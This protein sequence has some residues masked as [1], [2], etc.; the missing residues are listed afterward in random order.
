MSKALPTADADIHPCNSLIVRTTSSVKPVLPSCLSHQDF[1]ATS[2]IFALFSGDD[3]AAFVLAFI[4]SFSSSVCFLPVLF[5]RHFSLNSSERFTPV[6]FNLTLSRISVLF[7]CC[8]AISDKFNLAASVK[9]FPVLTS[10]SLFFVSS[11]CRYP[12]IVP[13]VGKNGH[14]C[15]GVC[16]GRLLDGRNVFVRV[17]FQFGV[18]TLAPGVPGVQT[19]DVHLSR[20]DW[21]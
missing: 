6:S 2:D 17:V 16:Y 20:R 3:V 18:V 12:S 8:F 1:L 7:H 19:F 10:L 9:T 4:F 21:T 14:P 5:N 15:P 13:E 11:V